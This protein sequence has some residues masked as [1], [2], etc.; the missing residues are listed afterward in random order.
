MC[1]GHLVWIPSTRTLSFS[2]I[3]YESKVPL[4]IWTHNNN[5]YQ[6]FYHIQDQEQANLGTAY[7]N[8]YSCTVAV[9][10]CT[11]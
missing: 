1:Y 2:V 3:S 4:G 8:Y 5:W 10:G 11:R 6:T 9:F 7:S